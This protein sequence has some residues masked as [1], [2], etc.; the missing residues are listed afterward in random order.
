MSRTAWSGLL[1]LWAAACGR[2]AVAPASAQSQP[3]VVYAAM[4]TSEALTRVIDQYIETH[5]AVLWPTFAS[6]STLGQ[7]LLDG[8]QAHIFLSA[9]RGWVEA[10]ER[11]E[12]VARWKDILG[13]RLALI[14]PAES[15]LELDDLEDLRSPDVK[16][17]A[18]T[19]SA[20]PAGRYAREIFQERDLWYSLE[21]KG[22]YCSDVRQVLHMVGSG[23][24]DAGVVYMTDV[25]LSDKVRLAFPLESEYVKPAYRLALMKS[26]LEHPEAVRFYDY[27][28]TDEADAVFREH[29]FLEAPPVVER[30]RDSWRRRR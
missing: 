13:N 18:L 12:R 14:V 21:M 17:I 3:V 27:L 7:Q 23:K 9:S 30:R 5:D 29:G 8:G 19:E 11:Y 26:G 25:P 16:R 28:L 4:S 15:T 10:L 24:V 1:I 6:S 20:A 22:V 2:E